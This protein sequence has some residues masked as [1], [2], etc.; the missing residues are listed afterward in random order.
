MGVMPF[1]ILNT[2]RDV[3][4]CACKSSIVKW[5]NV[6]KQ[7]SKKKIHTSWYTDTDGF[8]EHSPS[9]GGLN[10]KGPALQKTIPGFLGS[11]S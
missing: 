9:G 5:A 6:L 11:P 10:Y 1:Q 3:G 8:L 4:R 2:L 7:S